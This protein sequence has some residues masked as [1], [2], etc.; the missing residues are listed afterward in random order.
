MPEKRA[1]SHANGV[2]YGSQIAAALVEAHA[3]GIIHRDLKPSNIMVG[4][5]GVKILD[6]GLARSGQDE[7]ATGSLMIVGTPAYMAPEQREGKPADARA[8]IYSFG[9]VLY[10]NVYRRTS[11]AAAEAHPA[12][13]FGESRKPVPGRRPRTKMAIRGR[14][15]AGIGNGHGAE[16]RGASGCGRPMHLGIVLGRLLLSAQDTEAHHEGHGC[17]G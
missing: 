5:S 3:K 2:P 15:A 6:F 7:T 9:C 4:K 8:D 16:A 1:A 11:G 10:E 14:A 12:A 17:P 13:K